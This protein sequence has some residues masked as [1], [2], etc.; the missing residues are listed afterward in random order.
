MAIKLAY[1]EKEFARLDAMSSDQLETEL[2]LK[3]PFKSPP[4]V[5]ASPRLD[6]ASAKAWLDR[7]LAHH[8]KAICGSKRLQKLVSGEHTT[9]DL[10][11]I[12]VDILVALKLA[13]P[14]GTVAMLLA[15]GGI[16]KLCGPIWSKTP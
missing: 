15:K 2:A 9:R 1:W 16:G 12:L 5:S 4:G 6:V 13:I 14:I 7:K 8:S 3:R 11:I 10:F